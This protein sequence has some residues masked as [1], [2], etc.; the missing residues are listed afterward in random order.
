MLLVLHTQPQQAAGI[1]DSEDGESH[2]SVSVLYGEAWNVQHKIQL[3]SVGTG[4]GGD[5]LSPPTVVRPL[6]TSTEL[7]SAL[8]TLPSIPHPHQCCC[9]SLDQDIV[10]VSHAHLVVQKGLWQW[11]RLPREVL[12]LPAL[13]VLKDIWMWHLGTW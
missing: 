9:S 5:A 7:V 11:N 10:E 4:G 12:E 2:L 8:D 6:G 13:E 3:R 1:W